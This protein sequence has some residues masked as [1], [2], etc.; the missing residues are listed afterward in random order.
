[1]TQVRFRGK[2]VRK[3]LLSRRLP[4]EASPSDSSLHSSQFISLEAVISLSIDCIFWDAPLEALFRC[5][6]ILEKKRDVKPT[7]AP[8]GL[9]LHS[10]PAN[11]PWSCKLTPVSAD[12]LAVM[13]TL[14]QNS[15]VPRSAIFLHLDF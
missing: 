1:M 15:K 14:G 4:G 3:R 5:R 11:E 12:G 8:Y 13:A 2:L 9:T 7:D 6:A 10:L